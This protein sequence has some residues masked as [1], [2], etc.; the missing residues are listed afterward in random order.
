MGGACAATNPAGPLAVREQRGSQNGGKWYHAIRDGFG[1]T[2]NQLWNLQGP[3]LSRRSAACA[4]LAVPGAGPKSPKTG[5]CAF[6]RCPTR[7]R[8]PS[9]WTQSTWVL[10]GLPF[11]RVR[12]HA[13]PKRCPLG[14]ESVHLGPECVL[15]AETE[16][17]PY[18][19]LDGRN[20]ESVDTLATCKPPL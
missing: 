9:R 11:G 15:R 19:G 5:P 8:C 10:F 20:R 1:T 12:T 18:L 2:N 7:S 4:Q 3:C 16:N 14:P 17:W 13:A 6:V